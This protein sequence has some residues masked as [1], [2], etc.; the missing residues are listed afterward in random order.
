MDKEPEIIDVEVIEKE[1]VEKNGA[2]DFQKGLAVFFVI[3]SLLYTASP[4]DLAP[5]AIPVIGWL[6]DAGFLI[7]ATMNAV[8]QFTKDQNSSMVKILKYTKW[9]LIIATVIAA[10]L[11]GGLI[12]AIVALIVK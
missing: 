9:L 12:A 5:D 2:S 7:T 4:I 10:L 6:D 1:V 3:M 11:L 8:Q